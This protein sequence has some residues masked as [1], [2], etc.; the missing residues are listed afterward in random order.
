MRKMQGEMLIGFA[1][2]MFMWGAFAAIVVPDAYYHANKSEL[3]PVDRAETTK[4]QREVC[5]A[6]KDA[7]EI[8]K[9]LVDK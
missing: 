2:V 1:F 4:S 6:E 5:Y 8:E 7:N 3:C 9:A